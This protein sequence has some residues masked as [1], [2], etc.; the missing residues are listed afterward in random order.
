MD[1]SIN[2]L[3]FLFED[4]ENKDDFYQKIADFFPALIYVYDAGNKK[5][6]YINKK[7]TDVLGFSYEEIN[8]WENDFMKFVFEE[9]VELVKKELE[10]FNILK[11]NDS[12]AYNSRLIRKQGDWRHF[13]TQGTILRR[14]DN[15]QPSSLLFI[16]Q[17]ITDQMKSQAELNAMHELL[18]E[19]E[20]LLGFGTWSINLKT[21][22]IDL[23]EGVCKILGYPKSEI[24]N[25][26]EEVLR[27]HIAEK[28]REILLELGEKSITD[29]SE[30]DYEFPISTEDGFEKIFIVKGKIIL[31][32]T[33]EPVKMLGY[34]R[35]VTNVREYKS[36]L[37]DKIQELDRSNKE[38]E[39]FAYVASHDLNEPLRKITTFTE[40]LQ[41]K[42]TIPL[43]D[44]GAAYL[45][46]ILTATENMR[47]LID[48][49]L[50]FSRVGRGNQSFE[51]VNLNRVLDR[52]KADLELKIEENN[53]IIVADDLPEIEA[54]GSQMNQL[55]TNLIVNSIKFK[56]EDSDPVI[57]ISTEKTSKTEKQE[58]R[59]KTNR[60]YFK[61][62]V[63]DNGI[64]F[65]A[66]YAE[67][68][69]RIFQRLHGKAEYPGSGI[70]LAICKKI[71]EKHNGVIYA[72]S[73]VGDGST[74]TII[75]PEKQ[76]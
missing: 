36:N 19:T 60:N 55:F 57:T 4:G 10:A 41:E 62:T 28:D 3:K 63:V 52:V 74:F 37:A 26:E 46:R 25:C 45:K 34:L 18:N 21:K 70:G 16:A 50:E 2:Y 30:F 24:E 59:L 61:I 76:S 35:D 20:E 17:D 69:F 43:G 48:N 66:E 11:D 65:E 13:H 75:L 15:N 72:H 71:I 42:Y 53:A 58:L 38:L 40:R 1:N 64:G 47:L 56:K 22:K 39:E 44:D 29:H 68:I 23:S 32:D 67:R 31:G 6:R 33:G 73:K 49:L 9:D 12:H 8:D 5:L 7:V 27:T 54:I 14:G 51:K